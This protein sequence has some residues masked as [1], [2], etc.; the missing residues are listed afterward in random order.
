MEGPAKIIAFEK[1]SIGYP[2][3]VLIPEASF[4]L[5]MGTFCRLY[6]PNGAGKTTLARTILGLLSLRGG[7]MESHFKRKAY[8][9]QQ[10]RL[11]RQFPMTLYQLTETGIRKGL[12]D[13]FRKKSRIENA[14]KIQEVLRRAGLSG[15]EK[16]L[17]KEASGG[18]LQRALIARSLVSAPDFVILDEPFSNLDSVGKEEVW[19]W[20]RE[21]H[22]ERNTSI[23]VIDHH[24][25]GSLGGYTHSLE[26]D[27]G[28]VVLHGL[29]EVKK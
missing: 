7:Q 16:L 20:L 19:N 25:T 9:P 24:E 23:I 21:L 29:T 26:V 17:L 15:K 1:A 11:D 18:Q 13:T 28:H 27:D 10:S 2:G 12:R 6:G 14:K 5:P 22:Q 4:S 3:K 8:V